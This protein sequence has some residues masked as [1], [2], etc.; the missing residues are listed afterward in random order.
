MEGSNINK[1][2]FF[3]AEEGV[4]DVCV[5]RVG[6]DRYMRKGEGVGKGY[7]RRISFYLKEKP[8]SFS[9]VNAFIEE[10]EFQIV[11]SKKRILRMHRVV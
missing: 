10:I 5:C 4:R 2:I 7:M 1:E 9:S 11:G 6:V 8:P 3:Q